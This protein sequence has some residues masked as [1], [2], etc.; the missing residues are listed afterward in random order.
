M[1]RLDAVVVIYGI[2][3][4]LNPRLLPARMTMIQLPQNAIGVIYGIP[5]HRIEIK[6]EHQ[7]CFCEMLTWQAAYIMAE[8]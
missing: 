8:E 6:V 3:L 7:L 2:P 4:D 5:L 1:I